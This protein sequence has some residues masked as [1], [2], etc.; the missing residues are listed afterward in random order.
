MKHEDCIFCDIVEKKAPASIVFEDDKVLAFLDISPVNTGHTLIIPKKH[1]ATLSDV[2]SLDLARM[3]VVAQ[4]IGKAIRTSD[5]RCEGVNLFLADGEAAFQ[6][7]FHC[8][9]HVFPR[10]TGDSF[11]VDADWSKQPDRAQLER[12]AE[13]ISSQLRL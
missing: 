12:V 1:A 9:L 3:M 6:E 7:V 4:A 5:L 10:F 2:S 8:H 13:Q 11:R